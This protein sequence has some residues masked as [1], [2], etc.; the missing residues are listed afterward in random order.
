MT[1]HANTPQGIQ[2]R[3][4]WIA[5]QPPHPI[6]ED[7]S[8]LRVARDHYGPEW[9]QHWLAAGRPRPPLE[10]ES[11][12]QWAKANRARRNVVRSRLLED[13]VSDGHT[14]REIL[15]RDGWLCQIEKCRCPD[16]RTIDPEARGQWGQSEDHIVPVSLGGDHTR[17]NCRAAHI[18]CNAARGARFTA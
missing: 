17:A 4:D 7:E 9:V 5:A 18:S 11:Y 13:A 8:Y 16:G 1:L 3:R 2:W 14:R 6:S 15:D 12:R 10:T